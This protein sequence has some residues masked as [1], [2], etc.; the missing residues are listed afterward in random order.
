[1]GTTTGL[2]ERKK[3]DSRRAIATA[4][5]ELAIERGPDDITVEDI[6]AAADVSPRTV[7]NHFGTKDEAI[8]GIGPERRSALAAA[9]RDRPAHETPIE[10]LGAVFVESMTGD[11]VTRRFWLA[12]A[13]L[14]AAYPR[15]QAA[16]LTSQAAL[17]H[18]LTVVIAE[19]TGRPADEDLYPTLVVSTALSAL[20]LVLARSAGAGRSRLRRELE[21][22]FGL[23]S[24]GLAP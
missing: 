18:E 24:A 16:Q 21:A 8:L 12:R 14:V 10:A 3:H 7:F 11:D 6:A 22:A 9:V 4:A 13:K 15:L 17:E 2:R 1:M 19:R 5:L 23:L 20:R